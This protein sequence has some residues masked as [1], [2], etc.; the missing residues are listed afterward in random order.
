[1]KSKGSYCRWWAR[2]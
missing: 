2:H 1:M